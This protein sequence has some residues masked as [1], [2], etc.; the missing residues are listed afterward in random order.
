[1]YLFTIRFIRE[2]F[3]I[4]I[5]GKGIPLV[6][7]NIDTDQ[8]IPAEYCLSTKRESFAS[9]LFGRWRK[10]EKFV[11]NDPAYSNST[12]LVAGRSFATGSSR[13]Y[14]VWAIKDYGF[15]VV[16]AEN[17]GEIF[18]KNAIIN[19]VLP[20]KMKYTDIENIWSLLK[21][22]NDAEIKIDLEKEKVF[23]MRGNLKYN[24]QLYLKKDI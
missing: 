2:V 14:A 7:D 5:I 21:V 19:K 20:I 11:L 23:L 10:D 4:I 24:Y 8:I 12:I 9:A 15:K 16:I 6:K 13:E 1:M 22:D 3:K 17:F 18:Y